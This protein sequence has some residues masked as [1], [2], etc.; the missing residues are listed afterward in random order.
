MS[1]ELN[2][3]VPHMVNKL[4]LKLKASYSIYLPYQIIKLFIFFFLNIKLT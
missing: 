3:Y 2:P 1:S 4:Q